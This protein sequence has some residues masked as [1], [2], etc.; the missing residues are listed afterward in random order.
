MEGGGGGG[1]FDWAPFSLMKIELLVYTFLAKLKYHML[2][3]KD[4]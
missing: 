1:G 3:I 2:L 4:N